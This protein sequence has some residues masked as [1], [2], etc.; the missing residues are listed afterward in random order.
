MYNISSFFGSRSRRMARKKRHPNPHHKGKG[1]REPYVVRMRF[2]RVCR[3]DWNFGSINSPQEL[4][5]IASGTLGLC[6]GPPIGGPEFLSVS[7]DRVGGG[8]HPR[9]CVLPEQVEEI[10]L[11]AL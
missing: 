7:F 6:Y 10:P 11:E 8:Q 2:D 4:V 1:Q 3:L 9:V 5:F